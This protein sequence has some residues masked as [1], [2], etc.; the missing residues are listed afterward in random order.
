[1]NLLQKQTQTLRRLLWPAPLHPTHSRSKRL[2]LPSFQLIRFGLPLAAAEHQE[3]LHLRQPGV[4]VAVVG[5]AVVARPPL[6][7]EIL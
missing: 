6:R 3:A 2:A 4:A 5:E 7:M 1:M